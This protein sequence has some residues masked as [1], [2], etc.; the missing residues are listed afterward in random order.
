M[1]DREKACR[2]EFYVRPA[3]PFAWDTDVAVIGG[4]GVTESD[5]QQTFRVLTPNKYPICLSCTLYATAGAIMCCTLHIHTQHKVR[6]TICLSPSAL[7]QEI[8]DG[9]CCPTM[10]IMLRC[11][12]PLARR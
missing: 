5:I 1:G 7:P 2:E 9:I 8:S 4:S 12:C 10:H 11:C 3:K 6:E